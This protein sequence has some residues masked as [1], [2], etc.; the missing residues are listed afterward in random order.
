MRNLLTDYLFMKVLELLDVCQGKPGQ[1]SS[2]NQQATFWS[3]LVSDIQN[4][5]TS[6]HRHCGPRQVTACN[7]NVN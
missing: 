1:L 6:S 4:L 2:R 3:L 5:A 7:N